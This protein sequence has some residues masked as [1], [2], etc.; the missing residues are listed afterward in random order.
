[1]GRGAGGFPA[2]CPEQLIYSVALGLWRKACEGVGW[3]RWLL[4][5]SRECHCVEGCIRG[6]RAQLGLEQQ[7]L[8]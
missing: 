7:A 8:S 2:C 4:T 6:M 5:F 3:G 1:M